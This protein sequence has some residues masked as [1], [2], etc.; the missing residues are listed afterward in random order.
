[1]VGSADQSSFRALAQSM[2]SVDESM[3]GNSSDVQPVSVATLKNN[4][5]TS[6]ERNKFRNFAHSLVRQLT[7]GVVGV[8]QGLVLQ[9]NGALSC[10][11]AFNVLSCYQNDL[12]YLRF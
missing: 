9:K 5:Q 2:R 1:M 12:W 6:D 8:D 10:K 4:E 7:V 3:F 11:L